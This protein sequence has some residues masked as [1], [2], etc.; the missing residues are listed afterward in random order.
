MQDPIAEIKRLAGGG[1]FTTAAMACVTLKANMSAPSCHVAG[2]RQH[3]YIVGLLT[4]AM[5]FASEEYSDKTRQTRV[6]NFGLGGGMTHNFQRIFFPHFDVQSVEIDRNVV[7]IYQRY[8]DGDKFVCNVSE[9]GDG[10]T[11]S[12]A[13][14]TCN[15]R[16]VIADGWQYIQH[17]A[18][19]LP[20]PPALHDMYYDLIT[21]DMFT[22][23]TTTWQFES[24]VH[25][26]GASNAFVETAMRSIPLLRELV[27]PRT[28]LIVLHL[29]MD[30]RFKELLRVTAEV[31]GEDQMIFLQTGYDALIVLAKDRFGDEPGQ[32]PHPC[33]GH[34][35]DFAQHMAEFSR[36][37]GYNRK[38]QHQFKYSVRCRWQ[39]GILRQ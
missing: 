30:G 22:A 21:T 9:Y 32:I 38:W 23:M 35:L 5:A 10:K 34:L 2:D 3:D 12:A 27:R 33:N 25:L 18:A 4:A 37:M 20:A 31:F 17:L 13:D 15:S 16:I 6:I 8:F 1:V 36:S 26:S 39:E 28:G 14:S 29:H 19:M 11:K 24:D 7:G